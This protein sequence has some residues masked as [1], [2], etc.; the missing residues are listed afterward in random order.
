MKLYRIKIR[1]ISEEFDFDRTVVLEFVVAE[2][3]EA[4]F[5]YIDKCKYE[6]EWTMWVNMT[7]DKIIAAK[8]DFESRPYHI[9]IDQKFRWEDLGEVSPEE[10]ATLRRL[11]I[12]AAA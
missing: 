5:N 4:V 8:G 12:L 6:G 11:G 2:N 1:L 10:I 9:G 7:R 3:D